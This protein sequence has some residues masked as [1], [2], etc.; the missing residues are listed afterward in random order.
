MSQFQQTPDQSDQSSLPS[1]LSVTSS[2]DTKRDK[3]QYPTW[4]RLEELASL[5]HDFSYSSGEDH[6]VQSL[7]QYIRQQAF[8]RVILRL[9]NTSFCSMHIVPYDDNDQYCEVMR[10]LGEEAQVGQERQLPG[11][12]PH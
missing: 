7:A 5:L 3:G 8:K 9:S 4:K 6:R 2:T 10:A 12:P 1:P 11:W